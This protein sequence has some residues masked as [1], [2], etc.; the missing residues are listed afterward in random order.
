MKRRILRALFAAGVVA[1]VCIIVGKAAAAILDERVRHAVES[2]ASRHG[3]QCRYN[4]V[5]F[6]SPTGVSIAGFAASVPGCPPFLRAESIKLSV[7][8]RAWMT[9]RPYVTGFSADNMELTLRRDASGV[10]DLSRLVHRPDTS[11]RG[12]P[13]AIAWP[14]AIAV[15][16]FSLTVDLTRDS[17]TKRVAAMIGTIDLPGKAASAEFTGDNERLR[18]SGQMGSAAHVEFE[19][20]SFGLAAANPFFGRI[21]DMASARLTARGRLDA[22][23]AHAWDLAASGSVENLSVNSVL[24][25]RQP[26]DGIAFG[27]TCDAG[28]EAGE[29]SLR[30][31]EI[32]LAGETALATAQ[33][34]SGVKPVIDA[35]VSFP[36]VHVDRLVR[37]IPPTLRPHLPDLAATGLVR[38]AFRLHCDLAQP[39]SLD[40]AF[41][42]SVESFAITGLGPGIDIGSKSGPFLHR[43]QL[44]DGSV[45]EILVGPANKDF[46]PLKD[47]PRALVGGVLSAE[48][49]SFFSHHGFSWGH[50]HDAI[51]EDLEAGRFV[52]GASTI[53]M[54]LSKNLFLS[55]EKTLGR[56]V[57][58][59]FLTMAM[60]Q[61]LD[62]KRMLEIYLN[63][64]EWGPD[65]WG[66]GQASK[67]YFDK[68]AADLDPVECAF[69]ASIIA[70]PTHN[71]G[72]QPFDRIQGWWTYV[73]LL[74]TKMYRRGDVDTAALVK[75]GV[76]DAEIAA[77]LAADSAQ[78]S[79]IPPP[80][81][82]I[83]R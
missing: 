78:E 50:L 54:Q 1:I 20:D 64:I 56:K 60:E 13:Y 81:E 76:A 16:D 5:S 42:G 82:N 17:A 67:Y 26:A 18:F 11:P 14:L 70:R 77:L 75:A 12:R 6:V 80:D 43:A 59:A 8:L 3:V 55:R 65:V 40:Y 79:F 46:V 34:R 41:D 10:W 33:I 52:R 7:D 9:G 37:S 66:I 32:S 44:P 73:R 58:E 30:Q 51:V 4:A 72:R 35:K 83:E 25:A 68:P 36:H 15:D 61:K 28:A 48:D 45:K 69:L 2:V 19:A 53:S 74:L 47:V 23:S 71:W 57:E 24:L 22:T 38:G 21:L 29:I 62:K 63:I 39:R 27:F 49:G 31:S